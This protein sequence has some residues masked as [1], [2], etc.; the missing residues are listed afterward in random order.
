MGIYTVGALVLVILMTFSIEFYL[1]KFELLR[2][3]AEVA[4][5]R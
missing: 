2:G 3:K 5:Q 1:F 4:N